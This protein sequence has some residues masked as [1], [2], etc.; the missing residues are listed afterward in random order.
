MSEFRIG[1]RIEVIRVR[2]PNEPRLC[3]GD[4]GTIDSLS[5]PIFGFV[6]VLY[7]TG[8]SCYSRIDAIRKLPPP[9]KDWVKLCNLTD[10]PR[11]VEHVQ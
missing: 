10:T 6:G 9:Q 5:A 8:K 4:R 2:E 1:D 3:V 7:D 11:E